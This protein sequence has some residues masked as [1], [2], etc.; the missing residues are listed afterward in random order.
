MPIAA[1]PLLLTIFTGVVFSIADNNKLKLDWLLKLHTGNFGIID[2]STIYPTLLGL[3]TVVIVIS[4][5]RLYFP[6]RPKRRQA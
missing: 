6:H 3:T 2:L 4:G 5:L 1:A